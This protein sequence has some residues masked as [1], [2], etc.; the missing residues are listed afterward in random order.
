MD[1]TG[2]TRNLCSVV[3][4]ALGHFPV[5]VLFGVRQCGKTTL[6]KMVRPDWAYF[7]LERGDDYE[8]I[9]RDFR[10]FFKEH[11]QHII[12]DEAQE[13]PQLFRELRGVVDSDRN[14]KNRFI[15]TGSSS[16][17]LL[18]S[19]SETLAGRVGIVDLS[20]FKMN[21]RFDRPLSGIYNS[22]LNLPVDD[23][24]LAL[25][26]FKSC[27]DSENVFDHFLNGTYPEPVL[28][29]DADF[30]LSWMQNY[31]RTYLERDIRKLFPK[32]DIHNY[33][34]FLNMLAELSGTILNRAEI[35][36]SLAVSESTVHDYL[37]IAEGTFIWRN[38]RSYEKSNNKS[39]VKMPRGYMRDS[40]LQHYIL[41]INNKDDL[42]CSP[43]VGASF[44]SFVAE[45][46]INGLQAAGAKQWGYYY[47]RTRNG[48]EVDLVLDGPNH[49]IP[50]EIKLGVAIRKQ[51]L[52]SLSG[53]IKS[54]NAPYGIVINNGDGVMMLTE[55]IIQIPVGMI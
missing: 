17:Q 33:R 32:L 37:N 20:G 12:I 29:G 38:I 1:I 34:R 31:V 18:E 49:A 11:S 30:R 27:L 5:V 28:S 40:G 54:Y 4:V 9:T 15:L 44:E 21:E 13:S 48:A 36:R 23:Q 25:K 39:L 26:E 19:I 2:K 55:K 10:F 53:F 6:A 16:P 3:D 35:A 50:I 7:D 14:A 46:I 41:K 52:L 51:Q 47:Y 8:L 24:L 45:E 22:I 43:R 42:L